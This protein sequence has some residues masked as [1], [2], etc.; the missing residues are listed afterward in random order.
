MVIPHYN[1]IDILKDC[2]ESLYENDFKS[3]E[4]LLIDNGS[5]DGSQEWVKSVHP[6]VKLIQN[7]ENRGYA[8]GCNQGMELAT[9]PFILLLNNDT[10]VPEN[11]LEVLYTAISSDESIAAVQPKI[12]SVQNPSRFDYSGAA[13]GELDIFGYPFARGRVFD[14][15]EEDR[16]QYV[17]MTPEV[18]WT[19]GC[20]VLLRKTV[21]EEIG[22]LDETF[23][24]HQEE[25]DW[26]WRAQ[27]AGYRNLV[28]MDTWIHHYSGYT[29][30]KDNAWK[31]YLNHRNNLMMMLK[32]YSVQWLLIL[33]PV[34]I[35][36]ELLTV[37]ADFLFWGGRRA[38]AVIKALWYLVMHGSELISAHR[39]TQQFRKVSDRKVMRNM[40]RGSIIWQHYVLRRKARD[41]IKKYRKQVA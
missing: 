38:G 17:P 15:V 5:T 10:V 6:D 26:N 39:K 29:L 23:F 33:F 18:F 20:A 37:I 30:R 32:N 13:G 27:L 14:D 36:M 19:S 7:H 34:R 22:K 40:F 8:G 4:I 1:G 9:A 11:F 2:L 24:A 41:V 16:D 35:A 28:A 12:L 25:I 3:F 21:V 31:M